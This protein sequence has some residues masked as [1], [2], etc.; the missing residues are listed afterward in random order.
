MK[1]IDKAAATA[2]DICSAGFSPFIGQGASEYAEVNRG[3]V[4]HGVLN[5]LA[6]GHQRAIVTHFHCCH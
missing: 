3:G 4:A 6:V 1:L 5:T 2:I